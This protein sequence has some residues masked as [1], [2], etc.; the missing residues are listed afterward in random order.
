MKA[1]ILKD[2][3][4]LVLGLYAMAS[5]AAFAA[6]AFDKSAAKNGRWRT[7]ERTLLA[8]GLIG[9]WPGALLAQR[10]LRHKSRKISFQ[11]SFWA[12]VMLNCGALIW[13]FAP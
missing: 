7:P 13:L 10:V 9:G 12:S 3:P 6:Y 1:L 11:L 8:L 5:I 4:V 2:L